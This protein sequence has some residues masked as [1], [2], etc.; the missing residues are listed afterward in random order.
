MFCHLQEA[1]YKPIIHVLSFA[2]LYNYSFAT[3]LLLSDNSY[4]YIYI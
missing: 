2:G 3:L 4:I 1:F